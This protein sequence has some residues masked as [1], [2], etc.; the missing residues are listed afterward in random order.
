MYRDSHFGHIINGDYMKVKEIMTKDMVVAYP[1]TTLEAASSMMRN[2]DIGFL[3]VEKDND[4]VGVITDRDIVIRALALGK[5]EKEKVEPY[6]TNYIISIT[7]DASIEEAL[8]LMSEERVKRLLVEEDKKIIGLIS[9]SDILNVTEE[10][11]VLEYVTQ[12]FQPIEEIAITNEIDIPE[13][14]VDEFEL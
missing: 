6:M 7:S 11:Y 1:D 13:A 3:P 9:L 2:Y 8:E 5:N 12:I 14:E 4:F 10:P